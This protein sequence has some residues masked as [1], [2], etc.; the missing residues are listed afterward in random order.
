MSNLTQGF[1]HDSVQ[2]VPMNK[3]SMRFFSTF[4]LWIGANVVV[5]TVFTGMLLVPD[6]SYMTALMVILFGSLLGAI[7]L[8]LTGNIGTR[9]GLPTMVLSRGAFGQR[10]AVL[11]SA[12]NT[13][14][15]IGWSWIQAYMAG[16]S[17]DHAVTYLIGYS[18]VNLFTVI[19]EIVVVTITLYGHKG[20]EATENI[21]ATS[22]LILSVFVFGFMFIKFDV[23]N[24]VS[25]A[26]SKN[27]T[28][29]VMVGFDIIVAT[30]FSWMPSSC[31]Y[32]RNCVSEKSGLL[33]TYSGYVV[34]TLIAAGLGATVSGFSIMGNMTQTYDPTDL[35]G[36][37]NPFLG[38]VAAIVIF[39]SV[40]STNVM[41][42]YSA[43]MSYL[44]IFPKQRFWI[45]TM[46][47]GVLC[48]LG[49]LLKDWLLVHFQSFLLM[50][51]TLFIPVFAIILVDYYFLKGKK[52]DATEIIDGEKKLYWY[53]NGIN[54]KAYISY[55]SG[56]LFAYYFTYIHPLVTGSSIFTFLAT[57]FLYWG[58]MKLES[59]S[60]RIDTFQETQTKDI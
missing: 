39:F 6:M 35:I 9:T 22:M 53:T 46:V 25:M 11:P 8:I 47:M 36:K 45:P 54:Y 60:V 27:P 38:L 28:V 23:G 41:A 37:S 10:G 15:L 30:A 55:I 24:L 21:I 26:V 42:L 48:V 49:A 51:G 13:I 5:T 50:I 32:N 2:P 14:T 34:A 56:A 3:R 18:N 16:L 40:L 44:A 20:I 31:D 7:P 57:S 58:L 1:G 19:T 4:S 52:Y 29:S 12:V 59:K 43:T 17:L 33:G